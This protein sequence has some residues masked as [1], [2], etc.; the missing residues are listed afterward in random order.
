MLLTAKSAAISWARD[1]GNPLGNNGR[2]ERSSERAAW[3]GNSGPSLR[4]WRQIAHSGFLLE[5]TFL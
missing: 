3:R 4:T 1:L 2:N 5:G